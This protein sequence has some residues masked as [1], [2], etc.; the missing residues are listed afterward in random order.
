MKLVI[1]G[2]SISSSWGNG[3]ATLWRA[4][5]SALSA[6]G[7]EVVFFER[8]VPYY[9]L[10]RD[11]VEL[12]GGKLI[13]Y[14]DWPQVKASARRHLEQ[15]DVAI[16][17]SY[18]PDALFA[19]QLMMDTRVLRIFYDLDAPITLQNLQE[20]KPV[21]YLG[22]H[23]LIYYDLVLSYTGGGILEEIREKLHAR[24]V[25]P[26]YGSVDPGVHQPVQ[27]A[28][29]Y[30]ADLSYLGTYSIDRQPQVE[31]LFIKPAAAQAQKRFLIGGAQYS[32]SFPWKQNIYY[33][34]HV[35]P[36]RHPAFFCS[37]RLTLNVTR[38]AMADAGYCPS[39]RLFEAA[40]CGAALIS[41]DWE[42][43]D[44]F[45]E[46]GKE[47]LIARETEDVLAALD[48]SDLELQRIASAAHERVLAQ[49]TAAHRVLELEEI[50][51]R[52]LHHQPAGK[53]ETI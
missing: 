45:F 21:A 8:D 27:P 12:P 16:A 32:A 6:R 2:L 15:A 10:H 35:P 31:K 9:A 25:A 40:G 1:F 30:R 43:I 5:C 26:L 13:L 36:E 20:G 29:E 39:G 17:T 41:D 48:L 42:G 52:S 34:P 3:H 28:S 33:H 46:P 53:P 37:S 22:P 44:T 7:H 19:E 14:Q 49:H 47:I 51:T 50:L 18:C 23:K 11:L 4:L 38:R 24:C